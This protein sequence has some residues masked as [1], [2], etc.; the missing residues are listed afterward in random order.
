MPKYGKYRRKGPKDWFPA[1][2]ADPP[3]FDRLRTRF[4]DSYLETALWASTYPE[5]EPLDE[6]FSVKDFSRE[7]ITQAVQDC[8]R[9][10]FENKA[11]LDSVGTPEQHGH[12]F[13]LTRNGHGAGFWDRGYG[14]VGKRL[15]ESARSYGP[16]TV[17]VGEG[18][19]SNLLYMEEG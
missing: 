5:G 3:K 12:D 11:D 15:S 17:V 19:W 6:D 18:D 4:I 8:D 7:A 10:L 14:E 13:W 2:K 9:F 16:M 1:T